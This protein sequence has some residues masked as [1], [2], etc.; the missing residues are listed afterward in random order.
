MCRVAAKIIGCLLCPFALFLWDVPAATAQ[1]A[2]PT[3]DVQWRSDYNAARR[4]AQDKNRPLIVDFGTENC[5]WCKRLE[6]TT[7]RDPA[8]L[9][10]MNERFIPLHIDADKEVTLAQLLRI[11]NYPTI[12]IAAPDGKILV[13][14]EGYMEAAPFLEQ[15]QRALAA[16]SNPEWMAKD[17][18]EAVKAITGSDYSRAI[19]LLRSVLEDGK[20]RPVQLKARQLLKDLEQ[21]AA[22]RLVAAKEAN[23]KGQASQ[24]V[25][26]LTEL[27]RLFNGTQAATEGGQLL[28]SL[29]NKPEIKGQPRTRR[30]Q[31]LLAQA[32]QDYSSG[33]YLCCMDRCE[34]LTSSYG[35]L[36]EGEE[37]KS[38]EADIKSNPVWM[39]TAC[40][41]L[42]DRL[43]LLYLS[44]ADTWLKKGQPQQAALCLERVVKAFPSS[45]HAEVAQR[46]LAQIQGRQT[47]QTNFKKP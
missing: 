41:S 5:Y 27:V 29:G 39:Q 17:Y 28:T 23:D 8:I 33:N 1:T 2:V 11:Q 15:L 45:Q 13:T 40:E 31:E 21:Q 22:S 26:L 36:P 4:E 35:D 18:Q 10:L 38:L 16:V 46:R 20:D 37:A 6:A 43:G 12:V 32:K 25:S 42:S 34:V 24:A 3:G 47:Q 14:R 7:F 9:R 19:A 30:A 44:L